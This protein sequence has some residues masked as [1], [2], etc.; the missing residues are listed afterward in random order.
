[1]ILDCWQYQREH[2]GLKLYGYVILENHLHFVAQ[3]PRLDKCISS[4]K[5][6]TA[7][8]LIDYLKVHHIESLLT[9]LRFAKRARAIGLKFIDNKINELRFQKNTVFKKN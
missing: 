9:R 7:R 4:F 8:Q 2:Q 5:P 1:I 3:A 6:F